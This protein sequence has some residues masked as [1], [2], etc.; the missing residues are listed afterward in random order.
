ME[1][2]SPSL[3]GRT[4]PYRPTRSQDVDLDL[5]SN[6]GSKNE[7][8]T[9]I[10]PPQ[11]QQSWVAQRKSAPTARLAANHN[12]DPALSSSAGSSERAQT[13]NVDTSVRRKSI[14]NVVRKMFGRR[15]KQNDVPRQN[16][17]R[18]GYHKSVSLK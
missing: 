8:A 6:S 5:V 9:R 2:V 17:S 7:I 13:V 11:V 4:A 1:P 3:S 10:S 12:V 18:H 15:V 14:R 16:P